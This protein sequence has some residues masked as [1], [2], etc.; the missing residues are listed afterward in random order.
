MAESVEE[1]DAM[2]FRRRPSV[3]RALPSRT[4][5][6]GLGWC[7]GLERPSSICSVRRTC[8]PPFSSAFEAVRTL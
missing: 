6:R 5:P 2:L 8:R 3:T 7:R 1:M 4:R